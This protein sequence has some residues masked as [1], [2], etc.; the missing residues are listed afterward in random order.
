MI[1]TIAFIVLALAACSKDKPSTTPAGGGGGDGDM[2]A[3]G[4][5]DNPGVDPTLPSWAPPSC[6]Q[7]HKLAIQVGE[8]TAI[9][10]ADRDA[11]TQQ[12]ETRQAEWKALQNTEQA[13]LD[14]VKQQCDE[15][16]TELTAKK[17]AACP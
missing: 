10:Q 14:A 17:S 13:Q 8:C 11:V 16:V 4:S 1:R 15:A 3:N 9:A 7:Y 2:A 6:V 12:Y 5:G